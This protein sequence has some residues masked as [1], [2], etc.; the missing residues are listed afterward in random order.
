MN[1]DTGLAHCV[2][3]DFDLRRIAPDGARKQGLLL[4]SVASPPH[5]MAR[6]KDWHFFE[7]LGNGIT[8]SGVHGHLLTLR[9]EH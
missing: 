8:W 9:M 3:Y 5:A 6:L 7:C 4:W 2:K 1:L